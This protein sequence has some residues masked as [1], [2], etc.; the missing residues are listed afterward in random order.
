MIGPRAGSAY[1]IYRSDTKLYVVLSN[2]D[3]L[4]RITILPE[5]K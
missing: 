3:L 1:A 5:Y 4:L 2:I